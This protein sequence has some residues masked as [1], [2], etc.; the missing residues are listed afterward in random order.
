[1]QIKSGSYAGSGV[2]Q[3]PSGVGFQPDV[4][5]IK[6]GS[7]VGVWCN[8]AMGADTTEPMT[9]TDG[10]FADG[11]TSLDAD[12]FSVGTDARVNANG[13][14]Y[15]Y[16][17]FRNNGVLDFRTG[18]YTGDGL[19]NHDI[20]EPGFQPDMVMV[21]RS[22]ANTTG[23]IW[24]TSDMPADQSQLVTGALATTLIKSFVSTGFRLGTS[25]NVN[26]DGVTFYYFAI[27]ASPNLFKNVAYTGNGDDSRSIGGVDFQPDNVWT[28][29]T[30][31][32]QVLCMRFK[33]HVGD[34]SAL[35][36]AAAAAVDRIQAFEADG[37]QVGTT[38]AVN[39][40]TLDYNAVAFK[41]GASTLGG[42][43]GGGQGRG[44]GKGNGG[45]GGPGGGHGGGPSGGGGGAPG[46]KKDSVVASR[47]RRRLSAGVL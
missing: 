21:S 24:R 45:G 38:N 27:K 22:T 7:N 23:T 10:T 15:Y 12:G 46:N 31:G 39:G 4:V 32:T 42:G 18:S 17:A 5:I 25:V 1:M 33:D 44:G 29:Y 34:T 40:N 43:G 2:A 19:D 13:T 47:S 11:V 37:F 35:V 9:G 3:S 30:G 8:A 14:T 36:S 6:G 20:T 16:T 28:K 41:D 26:A